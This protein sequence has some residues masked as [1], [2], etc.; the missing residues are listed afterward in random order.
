MP[1]KFV[2][3]DIRLAVEAEWR[4]IPDEEAVTNYAVGLTEILR[5]VNP[6]VAQFFDNLLANLANVPW[7]LHVLKVVYACR[8]YRMLDLAG[9]LVVVT[10]ET[11]VPV[12][13]EFL[14]DFNAYGQAIIDKLTAENPEILNIGR[15]LIEEFEES[16]E[17]RS[18][19][20]ILIFGLLLY[21]IIESQKEANELA[22]SLKSFGCDA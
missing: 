9:A 20:R 15:P 21:K 3:E 2:S 8:V 6:V 11:A 12:Q 13:T 19:S 10:Y 5:Q 14:R 7:H 22:D 1:L 18:S 16:K 4:E 17:H